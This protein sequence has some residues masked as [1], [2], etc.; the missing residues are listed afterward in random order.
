MNDRLPL[1]FISLPQLELFTLDHHSFF[2]SFFEAQQAGLI[3]FLWSIYK[4]LIVDPCSK[5]VFSITDSFVL[6]L[7]H[8]D[9]KL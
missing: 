8:I 1:A 5:K 6:S 7:D 2:H 9:L 3:A 4:T